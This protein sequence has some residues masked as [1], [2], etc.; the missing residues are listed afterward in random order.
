MS[1]W[2]A[3]LVSG[4][5]ELGTQIHWIEFGISTALMLPATI[6]MGA[7]LPLIA[8]WSIGRRSDRVIADVSTLYSLNTFGAVTGCLYTQMFAV[9]FLGI[10]G[11]NLTAVL[12]NGLVFFLCVLLRKS[13]VD[14]PSTNTQT[15]KPKNYFQPPSYPLDGFF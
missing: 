8:S 14:K 6:C 3:P 4:S 5:L 13:S 11:T 9:Y 1:E 7:T 2:Y 10:N 15:S 12:M